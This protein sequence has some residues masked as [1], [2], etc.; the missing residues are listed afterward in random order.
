MPFDPVTQPYELDDDTIVML[1]NEN[2]IKLEREK[3][4]YAFLFEQQKKISF[5]EQYK[6]D[7]RQR[8]IKTLEDFISYLNGLL[9]RMD[10]EELAAEVPETLEET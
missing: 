6:L 7:E 2:K 10:R 8:R 3:V 5:N 1:Y 4:E 9:V